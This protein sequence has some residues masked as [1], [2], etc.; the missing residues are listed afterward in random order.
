MIHLR[1]NNLRRPA[2]EVF[3]ACLHVQGL[4]LHLDSLI[5]LALTGAAEKRQTAFFGVVRSVF[6]DDFGIQHHGVCRSSSAFIKKGND[7]FTNTDCSRRHADT[8]FPVRHQRVQQVLCNLQS[9]FVAPSDF[10]AR[11]WGRASI[12]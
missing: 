1:L 5:V 9:S 8:A 2:G 7:V 11:K 4:I 6:L 3:C 12:L 10:P